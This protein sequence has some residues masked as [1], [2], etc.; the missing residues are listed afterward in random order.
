MAV[1]FPHAIV[2]GR[3]KSRKPQDKG[4]QMRNTSS[5]TVADAC[6]LSIRPEERTSN[7]Y[8]I[9]SLERFF[10]MFTK[11]EN[12][13]VKPQKWEDPFEDFI[14]DWRSSGDEK[15]QFVRPTVYGQCW[16]VGKASDAMWRIYSPTSHSVRIRSTVS[17]IVA[18]LARATKPNQEAFVGRVK[19]YPNEDTLLKRA[20]A[21]IRTL[22]KGKAPMKAYAETLLLKRSMFTHEQEVRL[23]LLTPIASAV[24]GDLHPYQI[25]PHDLIDQVMLDPRISIAY[26][27]ALRYGI[28]KHASFKGEILHSMVYRPPSARLEETPEGLRWKDVGRRRVRG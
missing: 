22:K 18:S 19:I 5:L 28:Q 15:G 26:A 17:K 25:D 16:T 27:K 2:V 4:I 8:R 23:L 3:Q 7:V 20:N 10:E 14:L 24:S 9:I 13:L 12:V 6:Y 11:K 21:A 1:G